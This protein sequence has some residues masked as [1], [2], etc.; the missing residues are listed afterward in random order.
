ME[1]INQ[2]LNLL[3]QHYTMLE[4]Q[5]VAIAAEEEWVTT[6]CVICPML[7][8]LWESPDGLT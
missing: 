5:L 6:I 3:K 2:E 8:S 7:C 1:E 4:E